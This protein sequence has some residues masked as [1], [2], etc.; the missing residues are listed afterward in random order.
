MLVRNEIEQDLNDNGLSQPAA[1]EPVQQPSQR[2]DLQVTSLEFV[3]DADDAQSPIA[4][5]VRLTVCWP[6][7]H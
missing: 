6:I 3:T 1:A 2:I 4:G 5:G 7:P